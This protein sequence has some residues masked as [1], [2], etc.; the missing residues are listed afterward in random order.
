MLN[1]ETSREDIQGCVCVGGC[2]YKINVTI[3]KED[4]K[5]ED[6]TN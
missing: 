5:N 4:I 6:I 3:N 2:S 1:T